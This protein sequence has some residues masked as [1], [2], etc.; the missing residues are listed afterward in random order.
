MIVIHYAIMH[1]DRLHRCIANSRLLAVENTGHFPWIEA[2]KAFS[3]WWVCFCQPWAAVFAFGDLS[4][5][6][7]NLIA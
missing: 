1:L 3:L 2:S 7:L 5:G 4:K 6:V